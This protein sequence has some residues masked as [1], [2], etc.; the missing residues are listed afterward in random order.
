MRQQIPLI[1]IL[2]LLVE[3]VA[4]IFFGEIENSGKA[5]SLGLSSSIVSNISIIIIL[6]FIFT[7]I[8]FLISLRWIRSMEPIPK[9]TKATKLSLAYVQERMEKN[10]TRSEIIKNLQRK[11]HRKKDIESFLKRRGT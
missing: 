11:G 3:V 2:I 8:A 4:L 9:S 7:L 1:I 5:S 6:A 10:K